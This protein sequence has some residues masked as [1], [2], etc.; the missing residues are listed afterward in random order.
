M[1]KKVWHDLYVWR[2]GMGKPEKVARVKSVGLAAIFSN[3]LSEVY[4]I[5]G[6]EDYVK[7]WVEN[8]EYWE[9]KNE[10]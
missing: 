3:K 6:P 4:D 10:K 5:V 9:N 2:E 8:R 1:A 7:R